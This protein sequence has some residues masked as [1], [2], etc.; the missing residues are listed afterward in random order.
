MA[1]KATIKFEIILN[2]YNRALNQRRQL[3]QTIFMAQYIEPI[4]CESVCV[5][6]PPEENNHQ[7][8]N[9]SAQKIQE[10]EKD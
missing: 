3:S 10:E 5:N 2:H 7:V 1:N 8:K 4:I 6:T 9:E